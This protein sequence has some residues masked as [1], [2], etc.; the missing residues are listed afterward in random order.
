M[1]HLAVAFL[2]RPMLAELV[3]AFCPANQP[4]QTIPAGQ[5]LTN[6]SHT[7]LKR[8]AMSGQS[9]SCFD[10]TLS[11][12]RGSPCVLHC[13]EVSH[14]VEEEGEDLLLI[15][16]VGR[17]RGIGGG[18]A[19]VSPG[20]RLNVTDGIE[21][22]KADCDVTLNSAAEKGEERRWGGGRSIKHE[23]EGKPQ[24][25]VRG[26]IYAEVEGGDW[27]TRG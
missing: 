18:D 20:G 13:S 24:D 26:G 9:G 4:T 1:N 6:G 21:V 7:K 5:K 16:N 15:R 25:E 11:I 8:Q 17:I 23:A 12:A 3:E 10:D 27:L 22:A 19:N 14:D 2:H